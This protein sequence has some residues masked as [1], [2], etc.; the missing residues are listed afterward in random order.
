[1]SSLNVADRSREVSAS[2]TEG[3]GVKPV[4]IGENCGAY[5]G[6]VNHCEN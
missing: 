2:V 1:V 3:V 4:T 5:P 6:V